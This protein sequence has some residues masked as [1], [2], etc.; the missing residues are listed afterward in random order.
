MKKNI[1]LILLMVFTLILAGC[2][3]MDA[4]ENATAQP[5]GKVPSTTP[6][7]AEGA[8]TD[9]QP[10]GTGTDTAGGQKPA[11]PKKLKLENGVP[12]LKVYVVETDKVETMDLE[13]Y[14]EGVL[15]GEMKNNWPIEALKAQAILARTFVLNFISE[16]ESKYSG[17][18]IS[19]DIKEAQAYDLKAVNDNIK[20]AVNDT[21]GEVLS[22]NGKFPFTWFHA[23]SGG[24]TEKAKEGLEFE[25]EEP[26]Y[27]KIVDS[28]D[29]P[30]A[31]DDVK[32]WTAS[33]TAKQLLDAAGVSGPLTSVEIGKKSESGRA[34]TL[35][36]NGKDVSA[37]S[38]RLE[39]GSTK[40]KSTFLES[41]ELKNGKVTIIGKGYGHGV[42]MSQWGAYGMAK[43]GE[44]AEDIAV[45]YFN[46]L[47]IVRL[48]E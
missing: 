33:F 13:K 8:T 3:A 18:D 36:V 35:K 26:P 39:I 31:P 23:H 42:G 32:R 16:K 20:K 27:T 47:S 6:N 44:K 22:Y 43:N 11:L 9:E 7:D 46:N 10:E 34:V 2:N 45:Y 29:S 21:K 28:K 4:R 25:K 24:M 5:N 12:Q 30:E 40:M 17:A 14:L 19:T 37:P 38:V 15:A 41:I 1:V 48:W